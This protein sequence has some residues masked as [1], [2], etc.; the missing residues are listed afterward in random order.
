[1]R[2]LLEA[3]GLSIPGRLQATDLQLAAGTLTALIGPNGS[4]KTS[5]LRALGLIEHTGA[6]VRI[7]GEELASASPSRRRQLLAYLPAGRE[8][9]WPIAA[10]DVIALGLDRPD[11][12]RVAEI[13]ATFELDG[14]ADRAADR[15]STGERA[16]VLLGRALAQRPAVLLLD[17][18]LSNLDPYWSL[19]TLAI[20]REAANAGAAVLLALHDLSLLRQFDRAILMADGG[21]VRDAEPDAVL[22]DAG[23]E[24]VFRVRPA[25]AG[26]VLSPPAGPRSSP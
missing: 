8:M 19:R 4:G 23:F 11:P 6:D 16:R 22:A 15:L 1:M 9:V 20:L 21:I 3:T 13:V 5:L 17:E 18:P 14:L 10:R 26:W 24:Q 7:S 12:Q 25:G 2:P